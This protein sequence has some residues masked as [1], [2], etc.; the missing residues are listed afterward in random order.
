MKPEA[1]RRPPPD[2][3]FPQDILFSNLGKFSPK[4]KY[5]PGEREKRGNGYSINP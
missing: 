5:A 4:S 1:T 3:L 2:L